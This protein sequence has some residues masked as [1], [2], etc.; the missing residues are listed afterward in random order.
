MSDRL[1]M[2]TCFGALGRLA[3]TY[4]RVRLGLACPEPSRRIA[5]LAA[6]LFMKRSENLTLS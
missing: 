4:K 5:R 1:K 2:L 6:E 3:S